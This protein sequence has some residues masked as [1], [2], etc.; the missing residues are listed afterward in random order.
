MYNIFH[1]LLLEGDIIKKEQVDK[2]IFRI[3]FKNDNNSQKYK[4][5]VIC[6]NVIMLVS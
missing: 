6:N 2:T 3:K 1:V 5:K 4:I